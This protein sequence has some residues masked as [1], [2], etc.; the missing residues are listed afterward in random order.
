KKEP[1]RWGT[2]EAVD[3]KLKELG[4]ES[5]YNKWAINKVKPA[6]STPYIPMGARKQPYTMENIL[7]HLTSGGVKGTEKS[8][9][10]YGT[11]FSRA[12]GAVKYSS[13]DHIKGDQGSLVNHDDFQKW[14]DESNNKFGD[15]ATK[16]GRYHSVGGFGVMDALANAVGES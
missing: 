2:Q 14:K 15:I 10:M 6:Q 11:G 3:E 5:D 1:D 8:G 13:L 4:L 7:R 12:Q 16:M 9:A